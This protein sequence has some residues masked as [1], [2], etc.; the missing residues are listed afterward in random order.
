MS[1]QKTVSLV[2]ITALAIGTPALAENVILLKAG[3]GYTNYTS[4]SSSGGVDFKAS[5]QTLNL[6]VS[7]IDSDSGVFVDV[8]NRSPLGNGNWNAHEY[9]AA[10]LPLIPDAGVRRAETAITIGKL[11]DGGLQAFV[12]YQINQLAGD[13]DLTRYKAGIYSLTVDMN[14][15]FLGL[16][17]SMPIADGVFSATAALAMIG[18]KGSSTLPNSSSNTYD[19]DLGY[20]LGA[21]YSYPFTAMINL[22]PELKY[23]RFK[24]KNYGSP[25]LLTTF[26]LN[27]I[28]KF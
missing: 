2:F 22:V 11:L 23:Q 21:T 5:Y 7:Y 18:A 6:G 20:S 17:K 28:I 19:P 25:D 1:K 13:V 14:G 8:V 15:Y 12:G 4:P 3:S 27:V 16:G 26:G 10:S 9:F 24:P